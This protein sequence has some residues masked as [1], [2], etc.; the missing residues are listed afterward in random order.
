MSNSKYNPILISNI[1]DKLTKTQN[2][3]NYYVNPDFYKGKYEYSNA[4]TSFIIF[5][6][7]DCNVCCSLSY[8]NGGTFIAD[9][10]KYYGCIS[11][12]LCTEEYDDSN[13][14][15]A[16]EYTDGDGFLIF[17][18]NK[19]TGKYLFI[20]PKTV[21]DD[22]LNENDIY[23]PDKHELFSF[24][25][26]NKTPINLNNYD[27]EIWT[28]N[29]KIDGNKG[30]VTNYLN[31][32]KFLRF[33][34]NRN[35]LAHYVNVLPWKSLKLSGITSDDIYSD[36]DFDIELTIAPDKING[37]YKFVSEDESDLLGTE[38]LNPQPLDLI[39]KHKNYESYIYIALDNYDSL[40][41]TVTIVP[42]NTSA[43]YHKPIKFIS[44]F[45]ADEIYI[46]ENYKPFPLGTDG[47]SSIIADIQNAAAAEDGQSDF[48]VYSSGCHKFDGII[49][50]SYV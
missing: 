38:N 12:Y 41:L 10:T 1:P 5:R 46:N 19:N 14:Y 33:L 26:L 48:W 30:N 27:L 7:S 29:Y 23:N 8:N 13:K 36:G 32:N 24:Q 31:T 50:I 2:G 20:D 9:E 11:M 35:V 18:K 42:E 39:Y 15:G 25:N 16:V 49:N 47:D 4:S 40:K 3:G 22:Y 21:N 43:D 28:E 44:K 34:G 6:K 45:N 17:F 37:I